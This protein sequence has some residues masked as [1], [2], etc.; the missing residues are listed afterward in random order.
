MRRWNT[1]TGLAEGKLKRDV[2]TA[3]T[4][5]P[6]TTLP[7]ATGGITRTIFRKQS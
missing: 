7:D 1:D 4:S 2:Q 6:N 3:V 5:T